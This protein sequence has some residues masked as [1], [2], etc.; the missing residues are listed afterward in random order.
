MS[1]EPLNYYELVKIVGL[2]P[3]LLILVNEIIKKTYLSLRSIFSIII[4][5]N[6]IICHYWYNSEYWKIDT[7]INMV[8]I[9]IVNYTTSWQPYTTILTL[10]VVISW[11]IKPDCSM[12]SSFMHIFL[13]QIILAIGLYKYNF[14]KSLNRPNKKYKKYLNLDLDNYKK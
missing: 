13:V 11:Y 1:K 9:T 6:G 2:I 12:L 4:I 5:I 10:M 8:L 7:I 14:N 3:F